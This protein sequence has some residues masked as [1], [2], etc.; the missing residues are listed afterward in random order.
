MKSPE[1]V[2]FDLGK[3]LVEFDWSR[4]ASHLAAHSAA[5]AAEIRRVLLETPPLMDYETGR[6]TTAQFFAAVGGAIGFRGDLERFGPLFSDIF[7]PITEMIALHGELRRQGLPTFIFSNTNELAVQF[8]RAQYPFF[9]QFDGYVLS[10]QHLAMK[11]Q[12]RLYEVVEE[13][14]GRDGSKIIYIDDRPENIATG[15]ERGWRAVLHETP[16][17]TIAALRQHG[18]PV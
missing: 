17:Q 8:I 9:N 6:I 13:T 14:T 10:Y 7:A 18:L 12:P 2:V 11:P 15:H 16:A 1:V 5:D 4:A 3:V